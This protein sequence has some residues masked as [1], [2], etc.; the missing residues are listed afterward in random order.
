MSDRDKNEACISGTL[1]WD[2]KVWEKVASCKL[3]VKGSGQYPDTITVKA[4]RDNVAVLNELKEGDRIEV[5]GRM[6]DDNW[7]KKDGT[8]VYGTSLFA[9][10]IVVLG[11]GEGPS[12]DES[13]ETYA[14]DLPF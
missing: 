3:T 11:Q 5:H 1:R 13:E 4:F 7:T 12:K 10:S 8:K 9:H 6:G 14:D 2:P